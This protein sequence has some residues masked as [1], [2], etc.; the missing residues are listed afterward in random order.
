[1]ADARSDLRNRLDTLLRSNLDRGALLRELETLAQE[2][3]F[4]DLAGVWAPALYERDA[5]FFETFLLRHLDGRR[6]AEV[7]R[8]LLPGVEAAENDSLFQ[9]LYRKV[10]R[11]EEWNQELLAL[12]QTQESNERVLRALERREMRQRWFA[13]SEEAA[14]ALYLRNAALFR[15]FVGDHVRREWGTKR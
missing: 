2:R 4:R 9:S 14:R 11:E 8:A 5:R 12:A 7:I 15:D 6:H 10:A 1:M 3:A 13:L